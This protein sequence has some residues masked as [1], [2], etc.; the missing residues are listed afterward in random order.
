MK[1]NGD[2]NYCSTAD[3]SYIFYFINDRAR[4]Y[5]PLVSL[6]D[7]FKEEN[8]FLINNE[9][10]I[11]VEV[12]FIM[13]YDIIWTYLPINQFQIILKTSFSPSSAIPQSIALKNYERLVN[14]E[15]LSDFHFICSDGEKIFAHK[16]IL[17]SFSNQ[18]SSNAEQSHFFKTMLESN[19][20]ESRDN[21][22]LI[23]DFNSKTILELMRFV[24]CERV[25]VDD[26]KHFIPLIFAADKYDIAKLKSYCVTMMNDCLS[27]E[28]VVEILGVTDTLDEMQDL[29]E[30]CIDFI[31]L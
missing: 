7:L 27:V 21:C 5:R 8:E 23:S 14:N 3:E 15:I 20:K 9:L 18:I 26:S 17:Q 10:K 22:M 12:R 31:K 4:S 13:T 11:Y 19:M 24:Y 2:K 30:N 28:N 16:C 6:E 25:R 1:G 29:K